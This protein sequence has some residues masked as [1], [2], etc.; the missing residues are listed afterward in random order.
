MN[1]TLRLV[2][3]YM[4]SKNAI[5]EGIIDMKLSNW[6]MIYNCKTEDNYDGVGLDNRAE[7]FKEVYPSYLAKI[8]CN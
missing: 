5:E 8:L 1:K 7:S 4:F 6:P 3:E 2:H